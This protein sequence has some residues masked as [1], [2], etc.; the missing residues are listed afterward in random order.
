MP[1]E[2]AIGVDIGA[3]KILGGLVDCE[4]GTVLFTVKTPS[5]EEGAIGVTRS[6]QDAVDQVV[7]QV[8]KDLAKSVKAI[9]LGVAGQVDTGKGIL[10]QAPNLGGGV[11]NVPIGEPL[12]ERYGLP[13]AVGNDVET[14]AIGESRF[15][16]G[17]GH[18]FFACVFV[19]T[20]IG[21]ALMQDGKRYGGA[22]GT[23]GEIGHAMIKAGGRLCGCGQRGHLEAYASRTAI[24]EILRE[25]VEGGQTSSI[26]ALLV[27]P[28][29]RVKSKPL[30]QAVADGDPLV[31]NVITQ[32]GLYLGMGVASLINL[33]SPE[34]VVLGGGV[35]DRIDLLFDVAAHHAKNAA[36]P[37]A[38]RD[39]DIVR[40][41][42]GDNSGLVGAALLGADQSKH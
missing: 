13:V 9:G 14:A 25:G 21:G 29:V 4:K 10:L 31:V 11:K 22:A 15:G 32:A 37:V 39:V 33:W 36:L 27:D 17:R 26:E 5:P 28:S 8:P 34:R 19:G 35:I 12:R 3:T 1:R 7:G 6:I 42:L 18:R 40:A 41:E 38:A 30:S 23:A 16:A 20:G 24:V 2:L